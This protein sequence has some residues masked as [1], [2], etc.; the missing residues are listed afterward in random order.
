MQC[1]LTAKRESPLHIGTVARAVEDDV[2]EGTLVC[3]LASCQ[4]EYPIID[5]IPIIVPDVRGFVANQI[6]SVMMRDDLSAL[7]GDILREC[8]G[9]NSPWDEHQRYL[10]NYIQDHYQ[11]EDAARHLLAT[12]ISMLSDPPSGIWIEVGCSVGG[13]CFQLAGQTGDLVV[14]VE[15]NLLL[16][17][18]ARRL[19]QHGS[20]RFSRKRLGVI[21]EEQTVE[22]D[23]ETRALVELWACDAKALPFPDQTFDGGVSLNVVD[24]VD[25]PV[26]HLSQLGHVLRDGGH[27]IIASPY[28]WQESVTQLPQWIGGHSPRSDSRGDPV[29]EMRRILSESS[30]A[31]LDIPLRL[32]TDRER[33]PWRVTMNERATLTYQ[34]HLVIARAVAHAG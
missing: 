11:R 20:A 4:R 1:R 31:E 33:V 17:R 7:T 32:V 13:T 24:S 28:D 15:T 5:G 19:V 10:S 9:N 14:G 34:T 25:A 8:V 21:Y 12:G 27:A 23:A 18:F 26:R 2:I 29:R 3:S 30:P 6:Q 22:V 16:L